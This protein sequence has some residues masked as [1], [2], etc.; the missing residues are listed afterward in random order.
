M[1]QASLMCLLPVCSSVEL[2]QRPQTQAGCHE[3]CHGDRCSSPALFPTPAPAL[4]CWDGHTMLLQMAQPVFAAASA[5]ARSSVLAVSARRK[6]QHQELLGLLWGRGCLGW[7]RAA[8]QCCCLV[9]TQP[10]PHLLTQG[11]EAKLLQ[12]VELVGF[13]QQRV[14]RLRRAVNRRRV[15]RHG[16]RGHETHLLRGALALD[17]FV[18]Q[19]VV[20][21]VLCQPL[22]HGERL[23]EV[24]LQGERRKGS[25]G[26]QGLSWALHCLPFTPAL[27]PAP[28][29]HPT[30]LA[31]P[32]RGSW[33]GT[34]C[35]RVPCTHAASAEP[36][37]CEIKQEI[38][39]ITCSLNH[40]TRA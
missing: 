29:Q 21:Q 27:C 31:V 28:Q 35:A 18:Q 36:R 4:Q 14:E 20:L 5:S 32:A 17:G 25:K 39:A 24:Y 6:A 1:P 37:N 15:G 10:T 38:H 19:L 12:P 11:T 26:G 13:P 22:Q 3:T 7:T 23:V 8:G 9:G 40:A 34:G 30:P 33:H 16:K 2:L